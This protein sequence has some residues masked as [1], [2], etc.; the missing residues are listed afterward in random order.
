M[1]QVGP[2]Y[3][4]FPKPS[5][6]YLVAKEQYLENAIETFRG[7]EDKITTKGKNI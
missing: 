6:L 2:P 7:S 4:Y 1:Q 5:K 3:G